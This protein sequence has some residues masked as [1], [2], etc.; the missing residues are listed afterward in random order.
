MFF[1]YMGR[2]RKLRMGVGAV[3]WQRQG[4]GGQGGVGVYPQWD[5]AAKS[6]VEGQGEAGR[7]LPPLAPPMFL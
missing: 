3:G 7:Q 4:Y 1:L 2:Y 5:P 6:L